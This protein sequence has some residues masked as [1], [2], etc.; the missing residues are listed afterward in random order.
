[1]QDA[2]GLSMGD[3]GGEQTH[4]LEMQTRILEAVVQTEGLDG[5]RSATGAAQEA[6]DGATV[7][8]ALE[9]AVAAVAEMLTTGSRAAW[10][11]ATKR[12]VAHGI[13]LSEA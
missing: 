10:M 7:A 4:Q 13:L 2:R 8:V 6:L 5:K 11:G 9:M 1:V 3:L 12:S